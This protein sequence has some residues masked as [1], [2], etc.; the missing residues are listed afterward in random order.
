[1]FSPFLSFCA[2]PFFRSA[3]EAL[4]LYG[5]VLCCDLKF[6]VEFLFVLY[7]M[8]ICMAPHLS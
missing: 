5:Q 2:S 7:C 1:M 4:T 6:R 3:V 8:G